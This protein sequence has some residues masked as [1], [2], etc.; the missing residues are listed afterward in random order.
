MAR[1]FNILITSGT[2]HSDY[3]IYYDLVGPSNIATRVSTTLPATGVTYNDLITSPG[4]KVEIPD[5]AVSVLLY[6]DSCLIEDTILLPTPLPTATPSATPNPTAHH[7][8]HH[9]AQL[10]LESFS[11]TEPITE[12]IY[13]THT[14]H[15]AQVLPSLHT[16]S[17]TPRTVILTLI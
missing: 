15:Q 16:P 2:S 9:R 4:V 3:T 7:L 5:S 6:N 14:Y 12:P 10:A 13:T 11:D 17:P 1:I 8:R